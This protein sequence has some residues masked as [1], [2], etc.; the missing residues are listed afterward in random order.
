MTEPSPPP[1]PPPAPSGPSPSGFGQDPSGRPPVFIPPAGGNPGDSLPAARGKRETLA[2]VSYLLVAV[3]LLSMIPGFVSAAPG[4]GLLFGVIVC[5]IMIFTG[6]T[7]FRVRLSRSS[8]YGST[9]D[10]P[11]TTVDKI[12]VALVYLFLILGALLCLAVTAMVVFLI[13]CLAS[14]PMIH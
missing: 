11:R 12:G 14:G 6:R 1:A 5:P 7:L 2:I 13:I 8:P 4:Y 9:A 10:P 3:S